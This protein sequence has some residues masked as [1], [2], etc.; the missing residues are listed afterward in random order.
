MTYETKPDNFNPRYQVVGCFVE[1][2]GKIVTLKRCLH[3][4]QGGMW[5]LPAGRVEEG[6]SLEEAAMRELKE[7]TGLEVQKGDLKYAGETYHHHD[8]YDLVFH[9]FSLKL[10]ALP[11]VK[12]NSNEHSEFSWKTLDEIFAMSKE[13][14]IEDMHESCRAFCKMIQNI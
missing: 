1:C 4:R 11:E 7:E 14:L 5:C 9:M 12:I 2:D 3:K 8:D 6:E 10:D 13:D